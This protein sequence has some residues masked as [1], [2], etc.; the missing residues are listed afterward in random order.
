M[1]SERQDRAFAQFDKVLRSQVTSNKTQE[2]IESSAKKRKEFEAKRATQEQPL[3]YRGYSKTTLENIYKSL[4][5]KANQF[6]ESV[7]KELAFRHHPVLAAIF[8]QLPQASEYSA[9]MIKQSTC[10]S[11]TDIYQE[12]DTVIAIQLGRSLTGSVK[13]KVKVSW[14]KPYWKPAD[15][16]ATSKKSVQD[17]KDMVDTY[18]IKAKWGNIF[19]FRKSIIQQMSPIIEKHNIS[20]T[21]FSDDVTEDIWTFNF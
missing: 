11:L 15:D 19:T 4:A 2:L 5:V 3:L 21:R 1:A 20:D 14:K 6:S 13:L 10:Y 12:G 18:D 17:V 16:F 9:D 7:E 8:E